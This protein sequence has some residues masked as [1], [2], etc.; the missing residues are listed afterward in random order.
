MSNV[1]SGFRVTEGK[2]DRIVFSEEYKQK[3]KARRRRKAGREA[4]RGQ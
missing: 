1:Q 2:V 4:G 3:V